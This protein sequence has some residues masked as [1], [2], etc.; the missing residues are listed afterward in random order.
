MSTILTILRTLQITR[1]GIG[2]LWICFSLP[3]RSADGGQQVDAEGRSGFLEINIH[4]FPTADTVNGRRWM[5]VT[6]WEWDWRFCEFNAW[7]LVMI[8]W[9]DIWEFP[10]EFEE[11][12]AMTGLWPV[13]LIPIHALA[14][15]VMSAPFLAVL[16]VAAPDV[17]AG[18]WR[19]I[20]ESCAI[21]GAILGAAHAGVLLLR[22]WRA[23][24]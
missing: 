17:A 6:V 22:N 1:G 12:N 23:R 9:M 8:C 21:G 19:R 24:K 7:P 3:I 20:A 2:R 10:G 16:F 18:L 14:W 4:L 13:C 11:R 5:G 15:A